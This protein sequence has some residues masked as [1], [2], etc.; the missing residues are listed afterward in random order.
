MY[1]TQNGKDLVSQGKI[2]MAKDK[3]RM[4]PQKQSGGGNTVKYEGRRTAL[5]ATCGS[6]PSL[7][8]PVK[9][10]DKSG[11]GELRNINVGSQPASLFTVPAGYQKMQMPAGRP[12]NMQHP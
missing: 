9:W 3:M 8:F 6:T 10:Q 1:N 5:Q 4:E 7:R 2:Y 11:G 12:P